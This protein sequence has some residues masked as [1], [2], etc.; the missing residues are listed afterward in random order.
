MIELI[1]VLRIVANISLEM[2]SSELWMISMVTGSKLAFPF[3][4]QP[5]SARSRAP[6]QRWISIWRLPY[7]STRSPWPGGSTVT[8]SAP[9]TIA[10]PRISAMAPN[11]G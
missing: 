3:I 4:V 2:A 10:G 7:S 1:A 11:S 8:L 5:R 6:S 9:S